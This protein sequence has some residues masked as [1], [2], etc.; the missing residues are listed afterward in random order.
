MQAAKEVAGLVEPEPK[1]KKKRSKPKP[2]T[3]PN[4]PP[5]AKA[6]GSASKPVKKKSLKKPPAEPVEIRE[7]APESKP[8]RDREERNRSRPRKHKSRNRSRSRHRNRQEH[9]RS[10]AVEEEENEDQRAAENE[11]PPPEGYPAGAVAP[12]P[13]PEDEIE[14]PEGYPTQQNVETNNIESGARLDDRY[15]EEPGPVVEN[16]VIEH[17]QSEGEEHSDNDKTNRRKQRYQRRHHEDGGYYTESGAEGGISEDIDVDEKKKRKSSK[18]RGRKDKHKR[19]RR[20]RRHRDRSRGIGARD[21]YGEPEGEFEAYARYPSGG[22][23]TPHPDLPVPAIPIPLGQPIGFL[24]DHGRAYIAAQQENMLRER[25]EMM[26]RDEAMREEEYR[27]RHKHHSRSRHKHREHRRHRSRSRPRDSRHEKRESYRPR[28]EHELEEYD[29]GG[30]PV[31]H[32]EKEVA[33]FVAPRGPTKS[34]LRN[35][36]QKSAASGDGS[37][38]V[39]KIKSAASSLK[40]SVKEAVGVA[41]EEE[42][43]VEVEDKEEQVES[44]NEDENSKHSVKSGSRRSRVSQKSQEEEVVPKPDID[45]GSEGTAPSGGEQSPHEEE[46]QERRRRRSKDRPRRKQSRRDGKKHGTRQHHHKKKY[47]DR[48][49]TR[50]ED[51]DEGARYPNGDHDERGMSRRR[52]R[53]HQH[54]RSRPLNEDGSG[55]E[56]ERGMSRHRSKHPH[57]HAQDADTLDSLS[58]RRAREV[59]RGAD[60]EP[61]VTLNILERFL[62]ARS[63]PELKKV[64]ERAEEEGFLELPEMGENESLA[65]DALVREAKTSAFRVQVP[66]NFAYIVERWRKYRRRLDAGWHVLIP[67]IDRV[68]FVHS[69][70]EEPMTIPPHQSF[71]RDSVPVHTAGMLF[72]KVTDPVA[73][74]YEVENPY[75]SLLLLAQ[76][77]VTQA[78]GKRLLRDAIAER[79]EL[80]K[81]IVDSIN[82][83]ARTWG[84]WVSRVEL[85]EL[86]P[87]PETRAMLQ[88]E[89]EVHMQSGLQQNGLQ[90][91]GDREADEE[92]HEELAAIYKAHNAASRVEEDI[93][94]GSGWRG[95][96]RDE[97]LSKGGGSAAGRESRGGGT[98]IKSGAGGE[99]RDGRSSAKSG[100]GRESRGGEGS[101]RSGRRESRVEEALSQG[102]GMRAPTIRSESETTYDPFLD[103]A[104]SEHAVLGA[105]W[106]TG[107][108]AARKAEPH[109]EKGEEA[110]VEASESARQSTGTWEGLPP[111]RH[112][113]G[114]RRKKGSKS[115]YKEKYVDKKIPLGTPIPANPNF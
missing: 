30:P 65:E 88:Y 57:R 96:Q 79:P 3:S 56:D 109:S 114:V 62:P 28:V 106:F 48:R 94:Q 102:S 74:S 11:V 53:K 98:S 95:S 47:A 110:S 13:V 84:L 63:V 113:A 97:G 115:P 54:H 32:V 69:L 9:R 111:N 31:V 45:D 23:L 92:A 15:A 1:K 27:M 6:S 17:P 33:D 87:P 70:K 5:S 77:C 4:E 10:A 72:V 22:R 19:D 36:S 80:G 25:D 71:T 60:A 61:A 108:T 89:G 78:V 58:S 50:D 41:E 20:D 99:S 29:D 7:R 73:A 105:S 39:G 76:A 83:Q 91:E 43:E 2:E 35:N 42:V 55:V 82:V 8:S 93:S 90:T 104:V 51:G 18:R 75:R 21:G 85:T 16:P 34:I 107:A 44:E 52:S 68:S 46:K 14:A 86:E 26:R 64:R 40:A 66:Q 103:D 12:D 81:S 101:V 49:E 59:M 67:F 24:S 37:G 100:A 38:V 112:E